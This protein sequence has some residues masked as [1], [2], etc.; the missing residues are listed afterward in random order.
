MKKNIRYNLQLAVAAIALAAAGCSENE[1]APVMP[2]AAGKEVNF[3]L[4]LPAQS[5]TYY[6]PMAWWDETK[7]ATD[8]YWGDIFDE[9]A[10]EKVAIYGEF[11]GRNKAGYTVS[12]Y[13]A[14]SNTATTLT[15]IGDT[16]IQ[17]G[18][19]TA[20][21]VHF[22][23]VYPLVED[24]NYLNANLEPGW[25]QTELT[26]GQS[27]KSY[28]LVSGNQSNVIRENQYS[29]V[30]MATSKPGNA[31]TFVANPDMSAA[32]MIADTTVAYGSVTVPLNYKMLPNV[33]EITLS[34]PVAD[35]KNGNNNVNYI[36]ILSVTVSHK[37]GTPIAGQ[38]NYNPKT[39]AIEVVSKDAKVQMM[40]SVVNSNNIVS[41]PRLWRIDNNSVDRLKVRMFILPG[42][43]PQDL[44]ISVDTSLGYYKLFDSSMAT[45]PDAFQTSKIHRLKLPMFD[46]NGLH[47]FDY[48]SWMTQINPKVYITELSIPGSWMSFGENRDWQGNSVTR[49]YQGATYQQQYQAGVRAFSTFFTT[50][51]RNNDNSVNV[52]GI[53]AN[54]VNGTV[55]LATVLNYLGQQLNPAGKDPQEFAI[56]QLRGAGQGASTNPEKVR[57]VLAANQY[58][59]KDEITPNTTLEKVAGK[60]IVK[61]NCDGNE[62][63]PAAGNNYPA[64]FSKW[65]EGTNATA[66][67]VPLDWGAWLHNDDNEGAGNT[68]LYWCF[69]ECDNIV[70]GN[71]TAG[72]NNA[73]Y[74]EREQAVRD[75]IELSTKSYNQSAHNTW[76][77]LLIGGNY[78]DHSSNGYAQVA[79]HM[80]TFAYGLLSDPN[81]TACPMGIVMM[82]Y[83]ASTD[84]AY[85]SANLIRV[86]I[87][88]NNAFIMAKEG[89]TDP[90]NDVVV[91]N[92]GNLAR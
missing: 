35:F 16:G 29:S 6:D 2:D 83:A 77:Y 49:N 58:V 27:A 13:T 38:F 68:G 11:P 81:R 51:T 43:N 15:K 37:N 26:P 32:V 61:I 33:L 48:S 23:S 31:R 24:R 36:D 92:R 39:K 79:Q 12:G 59:Y 88:N 76:F 56:L 65:E 72:G 1:P 9:N 84:P 17:W 46:S 47:Q 86:I 14:G 22:Y 5:R 7:N 70:A 19:E 64:L 8:I 57:A 75:Y 66:K 73:T 21:P 74:A 89:E 30:L 55:S 41:H 87:N 53:S 60:I 85:N 44:E 3:S 28:S 18:E 67:T 20:E 42:I 82:N 50:G 34:G 69:T 80:N 62:N 90:Q 63:M 4:D 54:G 10:I 52:T 45:L 78:G 40:M 71:G 91:R 25:L